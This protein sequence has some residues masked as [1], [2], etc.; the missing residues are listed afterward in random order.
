MAYPIESGRI[1]AELLQGAAAR[2]APGL[3]GSRGRCR[4]AECVEEIADDEKQSTVHM[5]SFT[6]HRARP[7]FCTAT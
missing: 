3:D 2:L 5:I 1:D 7:F 6:R 4:A